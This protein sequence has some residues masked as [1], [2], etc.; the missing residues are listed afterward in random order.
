V[1]AGGHRA[2]GSSTPVDA[3]FIRNTRTNSSARTT[4]VVTFAD[5]SPERVDW[6][7]EGWLPRRAITV[8][9]G[10][11]GLGKSMLSL[12]LAARVTRT[13]RSVLTLT[14]EDSLQ[15]TVRPRLQAADAELSRV[16]P[17]R[18]VDQHGDRPPVL[19]DDI[20]SLRAVVE[21]GEIDLI[22]VDPLSSYLAGKVDSWKDQSVRR[23]L[24]PLHALAEETNSAVL[25]I[26]HLNKSSSEDP[27]QRLGGSI[28]IP[29]AARSVLVLGRDPDDPEGE[30]GSF[31]VLAHAKSNLGELAPSRRFEIVGTSMDAI[32]TA[33]IVERGPSK[34]G[35]RQLLV[36]P[37][38]VRARKRQQAAEWLLEQVAHGPRR[39]AD[40]E[41]LAWEQDF[42]WETVARAREELG[43]ETM[44]LGLADG[45]VWSKPRGVEGRN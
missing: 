38:P 27:L 36:Q 10:E 44:K 7:W 29:A 45:W 41:R 23:A 33:C 31:R 1:S 8:L 21:D 2:T 43:I 14:A 16:R 39:V 13:G 4:E 40:L 35:A 22:V 28:G 24:A 18:L 26:A 11:P 19:P 37:R 34:Y 25:L 3:D 30:R 15:N 32:E 17:F 6:L 12:W 20:P 9:A 5:I 42:S